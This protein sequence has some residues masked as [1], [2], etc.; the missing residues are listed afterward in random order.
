VQKVAVTLSDGISEWNWLIQR[1]CT[2]NEIHVDAAG[3][4][5]VPD[6]KQFVDLFVAFL[7]PG[8]LFH[9]SY[10][11]HCYSTA[12]RGVAT[13]GRPYMGIYTPKISPSKLFMG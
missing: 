7:L 3:S 8:F 10:D 5:R 2:F 12:S 9:L 11:I 4:I 1:Q 13:G 6:I